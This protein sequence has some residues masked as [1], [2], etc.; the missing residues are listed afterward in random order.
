MNIDNG[1]S[2]ENFNDI[3][4]FYK[5]IINCW[6]EFGGGQTKTPTNFREIRNQNIWGNKKFNNKSL[7]Y[8]NWIDSNLLYVN[9]ITD[10]NGRVL[11]FFQNLSKY[12]LGITF[13]IDVSELSSLLT[14]DT[15]SD[16]K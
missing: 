2:I 12:F 8:K 10:E 15:L 16:L 13:Q 11:Q 4:E 5:E 3:Q 14:H 7:I 9:D 1:K 6:V